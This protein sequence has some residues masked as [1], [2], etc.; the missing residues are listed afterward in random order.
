LLQKIIKRAEF[1]RKSAFGNLKFGIDPTKRST[2][3]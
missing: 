3:I 2:N 1:S